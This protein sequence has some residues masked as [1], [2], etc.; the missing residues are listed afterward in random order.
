MSSKHLATR[1]S[2]MHLATR[3]SARCRTTSCYAAIRFAFF[4]RFA[5]FSRSHFSRP[6]CTRAQHSV[7]ATCRTIGRSK[8]S[9]HPALY[10]SRSTRTC[11]AR[12]RTHTHKHA[13]ARILTRAT[14]LGRREAS[15]DALS[16]CLNL[17]RS[18]RVHSCECM[19]VMCALAV[20]PGCTRSAYA[21]I[22]AHVVA[23]KWNV[24]TLSVTT[25]ESLHASV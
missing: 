18:W 24:E 19:C 22:H 15:P 14:D 20:V 17:S 21:D 8:A 6:R 10:L 23:R 4:S 11:S 1:L 7:L 3:L 9:A 13:R 16:L 12:A 25:V 5:S 2:A